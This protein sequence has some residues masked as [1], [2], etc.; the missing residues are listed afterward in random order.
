MHTMRPSASTVW[1]LCAG[2]REL[3][4]MYLCEAIFHNIVSRAVVNL[5]LY[6]LLLESSSILGSLRDPS[7]GTILA[8]LTHSR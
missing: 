5:S 2:K 7:I 6:Y 3:V 8:R 4:S 1:W